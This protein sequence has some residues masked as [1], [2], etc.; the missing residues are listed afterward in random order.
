MTENIIKYKEIIP[1][2]SYE[3]WISALWGRDGEYRVNLIEERDSKTTQSIDLNLR[4]PHERRRLEDY[5]LR[6][7]KMV[8]IQMV[9]FGNGDCANDIH[10]PL[11]RYQELFGSWSGMDYINDLNI[12][13]G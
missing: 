4:R 12:Q 13:I 9:V 5:I 8:K 7:S 11:T 3:V 2:G 1:N 6:L 10:Y